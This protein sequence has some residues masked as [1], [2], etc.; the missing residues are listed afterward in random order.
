M[1]PPAYVR[2]IPRGM[3]RDRLKLALRLRAAGWKAE[4]T[5]ARAGVSVTI[6][7]RAWKTNERT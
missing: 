1:M 6:L 7:A 4:A 3:T 2:R 5:A